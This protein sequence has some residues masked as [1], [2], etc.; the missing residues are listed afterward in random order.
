MAE[1]IAEQDLRILVA[2]QEDLRSQIRQ[3]FQDKL[4]DRQ[5]HWVS[6]ADLVLSHALELGPHVVLLDQDLV[7]AETGALV[8]HLVNLVPQTA[9]LVLIAPD[10]IVAASQAVLAGAS[11]TSLGR[12]EQ[13]HAALVG[14]GSFLAHRC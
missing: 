3:A 1:R 11:G 9:V 5:L 6:Q 4:D 14:P 8:R 10:R 7:H 12:A 13:H 2:S